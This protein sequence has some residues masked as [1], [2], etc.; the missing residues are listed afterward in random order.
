[1][2]KIARPSGEVRAYGRRSGD[3]PVT[4]ATYIWAGIRWLVV[5]ATVAAA[6]Y[7]FITVKPQLVVR[8]NLVVPVE[9]KLDTTSSVVPPG[10]MFSQDIRPDNK[11]LG[12][13]TVVRPTQG[14]S[15][16]G[17]GFRGNIGIEGLSLTQAISR[18]VN[19]D[20]DSWTPGGERY[21]APLITNRTGDSVR[22]I[23]KDALQPELL[24]ILGITDIGQLL[25]GVEFRIAA[26][27]PHLPGHHVE[28]AVGEHQDDE[29]RVDPVVAVLGDGEQLVHAVHLHGA[30]ADERDHG[31]AW[32]G[33]LGRDR[34]RDAAAHRRERARQ[35]G[36]HPRA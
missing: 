15:E 4:R 32:V 29:A 5:A 30:V 18:K 2:A 16:L 28:V 10:E 14:T 26:H 7:Y 3:A 27:R 34:V 21:F 35:R 8:N 22:V 24:G 23:D 33:E 17:E 6:A 12:G 9:V 1:M 13:W 25:R 11:V 19:L 20:I 31:P 36:H